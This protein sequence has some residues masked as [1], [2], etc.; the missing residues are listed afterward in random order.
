MTDADIIKTLGGITATARILGIKP[1]SVHAWVSKGIPEHRLR[2]LAPTL[3]R[4]TGGQFSRQKR[5]PYNFAFFWPELAWPELAV[6]PVI[7]E[8]PPS[9]APC[10]FDPAEAAE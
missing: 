6:V 9:G 3:E 8:S 2:E 1:P 7:T 5:W 4:I 10:A